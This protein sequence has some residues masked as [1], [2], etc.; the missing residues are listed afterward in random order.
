MPEVTDQ[1]NRK[2]EALKVFTESIRFLKGTVKKYVWN[3]RGSKWKRDIRWT[4]IDYDNG[5]PK[6]DFL[7]KAAKKVNDCVD[8]L[9]YLVL[10]YM[11]YCI[12]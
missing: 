2:I 12:I 9:S 7:E 4:I 5:Q 10:I 11:Y 6:I 8:M 3:T 1:E